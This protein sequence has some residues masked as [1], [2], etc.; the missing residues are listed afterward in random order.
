MDPALACTRG[1]QGDRALRLRPLGQ[2]GLVVTELC[3]GVLPIGPIQRG[4]PAALGAQVIGRAIEGG[5]NFLD[6]AQVYRTY[7]YIRPA[8]AGREDQVIIASKSAAASYQD[9]RAAVQEALAALGVSRL[10]LFHLHA[11]RTTPEVYSERAGALRC[12]IEAKRAGVIGA[13]GIATHSVSTVRAGAERD[14]IDVIFPI[15]NLLGLGILHGTRDQMLDAVR[16]AGRQGKGL[17]CMKTLGG[18]N[19]LGNMREALG[20][21]RA[22]PEFASYA[23]G[24]VTAEEVDMNLAIF[25]GAMA[26]PVDDQR[27]REAKSVRVLAFC[28]GCGRCVQ[29]CPNHAIVVEAGRAVV[30]H[31]RCLLCGYCGPDCPEF[32]IRIV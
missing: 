12:L 8:I 5:V 32:A 17:Y 9:M 29:A 28:Q 13:V 1:G 19:L 30:D 10:G 14:D 16:Y 25:R 24:M 27:G 18:G 31:Q 6:T 4:V 20:F 7:D 26:A 23:I 15:L 22:V 3:F 2:T 11:A 21:V